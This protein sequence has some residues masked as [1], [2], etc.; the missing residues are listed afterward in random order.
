MTRVRFLFI[1]LVSLAAT[2]VAQAQSYGQYPPGQPEQPQAYPDQRYENDPY[3]DPSSD[4]YGDYQY[5]PDYDGDRKSV[6]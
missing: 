5:S 6:V 4:G 3:D 2:A 1:G